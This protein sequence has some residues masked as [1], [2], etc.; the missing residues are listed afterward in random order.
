M[1][2]IVFFA[3]GVHVAIDNVVDPLHLLPAVAL[4]GGVALAYAGD[5]AYRWRDHHRLATDRLAAAAASAA[6]VIP[7]LF[8]PAL[9]TLA[10]LVGIGA[11][12]IVWETRHD[13]TGAAEPQAK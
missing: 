6:L 11:T 4:T 5:V 8:A 7:A 13:P 9:L 10:V 1:A 12:R 3:L 2:G